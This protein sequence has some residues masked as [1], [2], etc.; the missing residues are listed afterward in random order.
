MTT[1]SPALVWGIDGGNPG[2]LKCGKGTTYEGGQRVPGIAWWPQMI[3]PGKT[4][5][6]CMFLLVSNGISYIRIYASVQYYI[7]LDTLYAL[8]SFLIPLNIVHLSRHTYERSIF[9]LL[10]CLKT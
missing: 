2:T 9:P 8:V 1:C 7:I 3:K 10:E 4:A 5:E 6:V